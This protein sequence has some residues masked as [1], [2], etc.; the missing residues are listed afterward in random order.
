VLAAFANSLGLIAVADW[1]V[2]EAGR[3]LL[4]PVEV[5]CG[6]MLVIATFGLGVNLAAFALL[7][8]GHPENLNVQGAL[9]HVIGD[10]LGS[11]GAIGAALVIV[12]TGWTPIDPLL[13]L[14]VALLIVRSGWLLLRR[15]AHILLEGAPDWLEVDELR[16]GDR[17]D[18]RDP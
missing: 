2:V 7:R 12:W 8:R 10:L 16:G 14:A 4:A 11:I 18:T 1:I 9:L 5:Q 6:L 13:S 3:R 17:G 15:S